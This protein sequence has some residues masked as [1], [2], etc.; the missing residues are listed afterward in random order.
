VSIL[1]MTAWARWCHYSL[2]ALVAGEPE[3]NCFDA[4]PLGPP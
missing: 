4:A 3:E 2:G 1:S